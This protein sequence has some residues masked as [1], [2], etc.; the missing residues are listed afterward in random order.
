MAAPIENVKQHHIKKSG[1]FSAKGL[2]AI[3][4]FSFLGAFGSALI[5]FGLIFLIHFDLIIV[6]VAGIWIATAVGAHFGNSKGACRNGLMFALAL[7]PAAV[8]LGIVALVNALPIIDG[9][10]KNAIW[11]VLESIGIAGTPLIVYFFVFRDQNYCETC[12]LPFESKPLLTAVTSAPSDIRTQ[13]LNRGALVASDAAVD[14]AAPY[15]S[16]GQVV[17][18]VK[19]V[20]DHCPSCFQAVVNG[21]FHYKVGKE[22]DEKQILFYSDY[23]TSESFRQTFPDFVS[24]QEEAKQPPAT[25]AVS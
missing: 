14:G 3:A 13:L 21:T 12:N 10:S 8:L 25:P 9:A 7:L 15:M 16:P 22:K 2:G 19:V 6:T 24:Q 5:L 4:L 1:K 17:G 11:S 23:W 18:T 20:S